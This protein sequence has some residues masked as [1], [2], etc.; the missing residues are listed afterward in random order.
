MMS[1]H[2]NWVYLYYYGYN[3]AKLPLEWATGYL[4]EVSNVAL[5]F[6]AIALI[7]FTRNIKPVPK[8]RKL[9]LEVEEKEEKDDLKQKLKE[10]ECIVEEVVQTNKKDFTQNKQTIKIG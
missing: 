6:I 9:T 2:L 8:W 7:A 4:E 10:S 5:D 3:K 1:L